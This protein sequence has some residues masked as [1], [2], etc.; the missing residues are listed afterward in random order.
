MLRQSMQAASG[1]HER[2]PLSFILL[3]YSRCTILCKLQLYNIVIHNFKGQTPFIVIVKYRLYSLCCIIYPCSLFYTEQFVLLISPPR[4]CPFPLSTDNHQF[5]LCIS[6]Y[7]SFLLYSLVC[8]IFQIPHISDIIQYF[9]LCLI[10]CTQHKS[11][12][13]HP[14]CCSWKNF[15]LSYD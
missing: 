12:Q 4:Y 3:T 13:V 14:Y 10:Y 8:C 1:A 2:D 6:K 7:A 5:A 11:F 9:F 15:I